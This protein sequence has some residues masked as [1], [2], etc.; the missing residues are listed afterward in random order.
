[1]EK[2]KIMEEIPIKMLEQELRRA[3]FVKET[4]N[5]R[6]EIYNFSGKDCPLLMLQV[7]ILRELSFRHGGGGV[8]L[9]FDIDQYDEFIHPDYPGPY[10]QKGFKQL[11]V[12][13][14]RN[15]EIIG[16]YRYALGRDFL[17][18]DYSSIKSPTAEFFDCSSLFLSF[19]APS[20]IP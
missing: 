2:Q 17:S 18:H 10:L 11:I 16:G 8:G 4:E 13:N 20:L 1:M 5:D 6:N 3:R 9:P 14:P 19:Y 7:G 15:R 12:W